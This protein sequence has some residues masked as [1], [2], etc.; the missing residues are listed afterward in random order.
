MYFSTI[1]MKRMKNLRLLGNTEKNKAGSV[2]WLN[3]TA[4][5]SWFCKFVFEDKL[6]NN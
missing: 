3:L 2:M 6:F 4:H 5:S 1:Q